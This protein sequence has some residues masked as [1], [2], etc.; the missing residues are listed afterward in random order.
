MIPEN[1]R[2]HKEHEW[3]RVEG[4]QAVL[5]ISDHAQEALG[6]IVFFQLPKAGTKVKAGQEIGE[7]ES[8]KATSSLYTPVSGTVSK[9]NQALNERPELANKDPY[10]EGWVAVIE[11]ADP[12]EV[13]G[14]MDAKA[15]A[16]FLEAEAKLLCTSSSSAP[17]RAAMWPPSVRPSSARG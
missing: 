16:A 12:A 17:G 14:L 11:L 5:G 10:G 7:V 13:N 15:Y 6:D 9:V 8:T 1:L 4:K 3:V 2:Y